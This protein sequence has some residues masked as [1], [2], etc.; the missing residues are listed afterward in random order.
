MKSHAGLLQIGGAF[1]LGYGIILVY[2]GEFHSFY[3]L[4]TQYSA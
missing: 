4:S 1:L 3:C 2:L